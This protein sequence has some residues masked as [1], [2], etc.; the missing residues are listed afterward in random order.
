MPSWD[1]WVNGEEKRSFKKKINKNVFCK[2]NRQSNG[3]YGKHIYEEGSKTCKLCG[4]YR[5]SIDNAYNNDS[6]DTKE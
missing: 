2:R 1:K 4:H 6:I 3:Q 5:K